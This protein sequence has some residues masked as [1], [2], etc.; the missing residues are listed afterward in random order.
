MKLINPHNIIPMDVQFG[1]TNCS[2]FHPTDNNNVRKLCLQAHGYDLDRHDYKPYFSLPSNYALVMSIHPDD[3]R[4][5][6]FR[7]SLDTQFYGDKL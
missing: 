6:S 3:A 2:P 4:S 5:T 7:F 1:T